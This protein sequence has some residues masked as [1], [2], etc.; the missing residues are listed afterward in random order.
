SDLPT[1]NLPR[2]RRV[3]DERQTGLLSTLTWQAS[4]TLTVEGGL[5]YEQQDNGYLRERYAHA[6][7]TDY[8]QPPARVQNDDRH[9][10]DNWGAYVQAIYQ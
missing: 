8:S 1:G 7:P 10:F 2:Q 3:W 9:S 6:E 5:N 4:S